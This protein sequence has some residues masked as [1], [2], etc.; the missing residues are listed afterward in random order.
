MALIATEPKLTEGIPPEHIAIVTR[1]VTRL[2]RIQSLAP[3]ADAMK[4]LASKNISSSQDVLNTPPGNFMAAM[5]GSITEKE[6][7]LVIANA[8]SI[9]LRNENLLVD[10]LQLVKGSGLS[11]L[12]GE[13][14]PS[15]RRFQVQSFLDNSGTNLSLENLFGSMDQSISNPSSTVYSPASYFVE[16][17]MYLRNNNLDP[18]TLNSH[19]SVKGEPDSIKN[20]PLE[21]LFRR[22]PDLGDLELTP[23]NTDTVLPYIDLANEVMESFIVNLPE[24]RGDAN[25][26]KQVTL[27]AFNVGSEDTQELLSQPQNVNEN[28]YRELA[29][30]VYPTSLPYHH[31]LDTQ[32]VFLDFL[33]VN[34]KDLLDAFRPHPPKPADNQINNYQRQALDNQVNCEVIGLVQEEFLILT[35]KVFWPLNFFEVTEGI[36]LSDEEYER[37]VGLRSPWECWGYRDQKSLFATDRSGLQFVKAQLL[38]RAGIAYTDLVDIVQTNFANP[39]LPTG[40]SKTIFDQL[41][42]SYRFLQ[43]LVDP[44][45][46]GPSRYGRLA[47]FLI[48][49]QHLLSLGASIQSLGAT[50]E[51]GS[52]ST[53]GTQR[54]GRIKDQDLKNWVINNF[55]RMG[56]IT[57]LESGEGPTLEVSGLVMVVNTGPSASNLQPMNS[58]LSPQGDVKD[59]SGNTI[60]RVIISGKVLYGNPVDQITLNAKFPALNFSL[61]PSMPPPTSHPVPWMIA[62]GFLKKRSQPPAIVEWIIN[63]G[64]GGSGSIE[65]VTL[66]H[67]DGSP[68]SIIEW[69]RLHRFIRIWRKLGWTITETDRALTGL[70]VKKDQASQRSSQPVPNGDLNTETFSDLITFDDFVDSPSSGNGG[71]GG[72]DEDDGSFSPG[73]NLALADITV[74][75][76]EQLA[77]VKQ[78]LPMTSLTVEQLLI[79]WTAM[80]SRGKSSL[81]YRLFFTRNLRNTD[82]AFGPDPN[83]DYFTGKPQT[84]RGHR[85]MIMAALSLSMDDIEFLLPSTV[86]DILNMDNLSAIYRCSLMASVLGVKISDLTQIINGIGNPFASPVACLTVL[87]TWEKMKSIPFPWEELRYILDSVPSPTDPLAPTKLDSLRVSKELHDGITDIQNSHPF[88]D[89]ESEATDDLIANTV[90][91]IFSSQIAAG[92]LGLIHGTTVYTTSTAPIVLDEN[93]PDMVAKSVPG[94]KIAYTVPAASNSDKKASTNPPKLQVTGILTEAEIDNSQSAITIAWTKAVDSVCAQ[95]NNFFYDN[96]AGIFPD[97]SDVSNRNLLAGDIAPSSEVKKAPNGTAPATNPAPAPEIPQPEPT[98][99]RKALYFLKFFIP[100]LQETLAHS[101]V[102][103]TVASEAGFQDHTLAKT[104]LENIVVLDDS[105]Q[106]AIQFLLQTVGSSADMWQ[107]YMSPN[108]PTETVDKYIFYLPDGPKPPPLAIDGATKPFISKPVGTVKMWQTEPITLDSTKVYTRILPGDLWWK[109]GKSPRSNIPDSNFLPDFATGQMF[110][111]FE[112]LKKLALLLNRFKLSSD[113]IRYMNGHSGRNEPFDGLTFNNLADIAHWERIYSFTTLRNSLPANQPKGLLDLFAWSTTNAGADGDDRTQ[114]AQQISDVTSWPIYMLIPMLTGIN[115]STGKA[116]SFR[117]EQILYRLQKLVALANQLKVD[118]PRLFAW[119]SPLGTGTRDYF[120]Y[121]AVAQD[122]QRVARSRF[123][124]TSWAD[125]VR[126]MN[127]KLRENQKSGLISYLLVQQDLVEEANITDA[128]SLFEYFLID[129]NMTPLVQT[130]RIKQAISTVQLYIQRCMLGLEEDK[131]V[132]VSA[133]NRPRWE[134]MQKYRVWEANRKIYLYPENWIEPTLRDDKSEFFKQLESALLQK[135]LNNNVVYEAIRS[136]LYQVDTVS[137]LEAIGL[138]VDFQDGNRV[139]IVARTRTSPLGYFYNSFLP[140]DGGYWKGWKTMAVDIPH[141]TIPETGMIGNYVSPIVYNGRVIIFVAQILNHVIPADTNKPHLKATLDDVRNASIGDV[142]PRNAWEIQMSW[143][144]YRNGKWTARQTCPSSYIDI[145]VNQDDVAKYSDLSN[146][147]GQEAAARLVDFTTA[148]TK[149][150]AALGADSATVEGSQKDVDDAQKALTAANIKAQHAS[151]TVFRLKTDLDLGPATIESYRFVPSLAQEAGSEPTTPASAVRI[152]VSKFRSNVVSQP[153]YHKYIHQLIVSSAGSGDVAKVFSALG[154]IETNSTKDFQD[155]FGGSNGTFNELGSIYSLYNWELGLHAPMTLIDRLHK[156]QQYEQALNVCHYV[157]NP[158]NANDLNLANGSKDIGRFWVFPPFKSIQR[159]TVESIFAKLQPGNPDPAIT[160]WRKSPFNPHVVA[161]NRPQAYMKWI[162]MTYI[163]ILIDYGDSL[164]RQ[165]TLET[166]PLA[167][168]L[169]VLASHIYGPRG[170]IVPRRDEN[171]KAATYNQLATQFDAFGNAMVQ[172]EEAFPFSNQTPLPINRIQATEKDVQLANIFGGAGS[173]YF[174]IPDNPDLRA[175]A[176]TIDDRLF[177]IRHSQD[178]NG[179]FRQLPLFEPPIDPALLVQATGQGL[180]ISSVLS[181]LNGPMPTC[182]FFYL[183]NKALELA[184]ETKSLGNALLSVSEKKDAETYSALLASH[185]LASQ[186]AVMDLKKL[187][188]E[189]AKHS[190]AQLQYQRRA[191]VSRLTYFIN[192]VGGNLSGVPDLDREFLELD[193]KIETPVSSGGFAL[194]PMESQEMQLAG[195]IADV[196]IL[197]GSLE[198]A[199]GLLYAIPTLMMNGSPIGIGTSAVIN[200]QNF[201]ALASSYAKGIGIGVEN[202]QYQTNSLTKKGQYQ[203]AL[204]DRIMQA[205]NAGYE[206][207]QIDKQIT[208]AKIRIDMANKEIELQQSTIDQSQERVDFVRNKYSNAELYSW[209]EGQTKTLFYNSYSQAFALAQKAEKAFKFER[210]QKTSTSYIQQGYWDVSRNGLLSG[211]GLYLALKNLESAYQ[212]ERGYDYEVSKPISLR[213]LDPLALISLREGGSAKFSIPEILFDMDF[214]GHYLRR[215]KGVSITMPC[216]VGPY[217]GINATL[218]LT[219]SKYRISP[220]TTPQYV[221]TIDSSSATDPHFAIVSVPIKSIAVSGGQN[222]NGVLELDFRDECSR[223]L[224]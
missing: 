202:M 97:E 65:N 155:A 35:K 76:I 91:L 2:A 175:L 64:R 193:A 29:S 165:N 120:R 92:V 183:L 102:I 111:L 189:D 203:R 109:P 169:Y 39:K 66:S 30:A 12:D 104:M 70:S 116:S 151:L 96:L 117:D 54:S 36:Q 209:M 61:I 11:V 208:A 188:V 133:L 129:V 53:T 59:A 60:A 13:E 63:E 128:D 88:I 204:Q 103:T 84:I 7:T 131:G 108:T 152:Y 27:D 107:G 118:V 148:Q 62:D 41:R 166:I 100:F 138:Y 124:L 182:R 144:E 1:E 112:K 105:G 19:A 140:A 40:K 69:D 132:K 156:A 206:I 18:Q 6:A 194:S 67:L 179:V 163:K 123:S 37:R 224:P 222:D 198:T 45:S 130:S 207:S 16:L 101:F 141:Y 83:G 82:A 48:R 212:D 184:S 167:I 150:S 72:G 56:Q 196:N 79:F 154:G 214:P 210:P 200:G 44:G 26:P 139:H 89:K 49:S 136:F 86:D 50:N 215:L 146:K 205:N 162:V 172:L 115:F 9:K 17:L 178:I 110:S 216:I 20:T 135:D 218:T 81:Y 73:P 32:R 113:E 24:F 74:S 213:R 47:D 31:P 95:S 158:L 121:S 149:L 177:K 99:G 220:S 114:L 22:R 142:T 3:S 127:D 21:F 173:L 42:F 71:G 57:V 164:F 58:V 77:A 153:F 174:A 221:E 46:T 219:N 170:K 28:A 43:T 223:Y 126:P 98:T 15:T 87:Q 201:G 217:T 191:P 195:S 34:R 134:W 137:N 143:T 171:I 25:V 51:N 157:F 147:A 187:A 93:F 78:I 94:K 185:E 55:E 199:A 5:K 180:S 190:L 168:Q 10:L 211:E 68:L 197:V 4:T 176:D 119:A 160:A 23:E 80:S 14:M 106:S 161:R 192:L 52:A 90:G 181:S 186:T 145:P 125:A 159:A 75:V 8:V 38:Q 122:I 85:V 33:K